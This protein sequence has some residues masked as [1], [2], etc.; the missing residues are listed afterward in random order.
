MALYS[1]YLIYASLG[2]MWFGGLIN[3]ET[4]EGF[5]EDIVDE[6]WVYLN[7]N[8]FIMA[9]NTLFGFMWQNDWEA[10]VFM[11]QEAVGHDGDGLVL[12]FFISFMQISNL[13]FLNIIIAFVIDTYSSIEETLQQEKRQRANKLQKLDMDEDKSLLR[14]LNDNPG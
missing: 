6:S 3:T 4:I 8:D 14:E 5:D 12:F 13:L 11:Y 9:M 2:I 7:F 10:L 1:L